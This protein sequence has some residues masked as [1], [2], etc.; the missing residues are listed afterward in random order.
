[1]IITENLVGCWVDGSH[2]SAEDLCKDIIYVMNKLIERTFNNFSLLFS[3]N[4]N[5]EFLHEIADDAISF[6]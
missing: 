1:M 6:L 3:L 4:D 2:R 5:E